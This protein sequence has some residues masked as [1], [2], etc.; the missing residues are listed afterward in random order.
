MG[1]PPPLDFGTRHLLPLERN[2]E[3]I[4]VHALCIYLQTVNMYALFT[5]W[6][7]WWGGGRDTT[8]EIKIMCRLIY[9]PHTF[10]LVKFL[11]AKRLMHTIKYRVEIS[12]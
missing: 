5:S 6:W 1:L 12:L 11:P 3:I 8:L 7:K 9:T 4:T 10:S 2:P